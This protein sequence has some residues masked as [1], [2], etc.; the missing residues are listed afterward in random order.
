M[1]T[2]INS[3]HRALQRLPSEFRKCEDEQLLSS[4]TVSTEQLVSVKE[5]Q[6]QMSVGRSNVYQVKQGKNSIYYLLSD[7]ISTE[8]PMVT[9]FEA[10]SC[11]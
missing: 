5:I 2:K 3:L 7:I 10:T 8:S 11:D 9:E 6:R 4:F 1:L